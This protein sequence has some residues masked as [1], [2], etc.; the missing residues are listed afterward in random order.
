MVKHPVHT[1]RS[2]YRGSDPKKRQKAA[3]ENRVSAA[4]EAHINKL[5]LE[6]EDPIYSYMY[7]IISHE[8]GYS[9]RQVEE[10]CYQ[11]D[12]G[13]NG[14]TVIRHDLSYDQAL[15]LNRG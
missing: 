6:Q 1:K 13:S 11:I 3:E 12:C 7:T 8:T 10:A 9:F 2:S 14:F 4:I 15:A 5:L